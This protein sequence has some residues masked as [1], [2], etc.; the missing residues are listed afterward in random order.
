MSDTTLNPQTPITPEDQAN[1][2]SDLP[3]IEASSGAAPV[4]GTP[5]QAHPS[6][7]RQLL[8]AVIPDVEDE[9]PQGLS[10]DM[11]D[12]DAESALAYQSLMRHRKE[13]R[14]KKII[15]GVI[16]LCVVAAVGAFLAIRSCSGHNGE[17][18]MPTMQ[19]DYVYRDAFRE[20]I[21]ATGSARPDSSV[22]V[23]P[24]AGTVTGV[25]VA[26][27]DEV[28]VGQTLV[29]IENGSLDKAVSDA[30]FAYKEAEAAVDT[31]QQELNAVWYG[32]DQAAKDTAYITLEKAKA[33]R[34]SALE[35][36]Q[37]AVDEADNRDL[38]APISG[39][40]IS[41]GLQ[42]GQKIGEGTAGTGANETI[43]I[44][45]LSKMRVTVEVSEID[46]TKIS[47]GQ[48]ATV[49]FSALPDVELE[50]EVVNIAAASS[51]S[52]EGGYG[53]GGNVTYAVE[54]LIPEPDPQIKPG[55]TASVRIDVQALDDVLMVPVSALQTDDGENYYVFVVTDLE[56]EEVEMRPVT[57][58][59]EGTSSAAVEGDLAE[60]D[61]V[62]IVYSWDMGYA[63]DGDYGAATMEG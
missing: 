45:D 56:A 5:A 53:Y 32:D 62:Q 60:G 30:W 3:V 15:R 48:G 29:T 43:Q 28:T 54:L 57:V 13:R 35:A 61:M 31:A 41:M 22:V 37:D 38:K 42:V 25:E 6:K 2:L 26:A 9:R 17:E 11:D 46:I 10:E 50:A 18:D 20:S 21:S 59:A 44:A 47:V 14:R 1:P 51:G 36:Y 49:T 27:G 63:E 52:S 12:E 39:T 24:V 23:N 8:D 55:M 19:V 34:D 7:A 33:T 58:L 16:A 4:G 40:V